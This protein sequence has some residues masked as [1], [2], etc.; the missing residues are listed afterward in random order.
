MIIKQGFFQLV[1]TVFLFGFAL[2][3][4]SAA[5]GSVTQRADTPTSETILLT[6]PVLKINRG[7]GDQ[8]IFDCPDAQ[9][10]SLSGE[11]QI[12]W[13]VMTV[14]LPPDADMSRLSCSITKVKYEP[15]K[16]Q[17]QVSPKPPM[18]TLQNDKPVKIW[19][20]NKTIVNGKDAD[21]YSQNDF[22]PKQQPRILHT[23]K[24]HKYQLAQIAVPLVRYHPINNKLKK[25][26]RAEVTLTFNKKTAHNSKK[27]KSNG[28]SKAAYKRRV[29]EL[30]DNSHASIGLY[31]ESIGEGADLTNMQSMSDPNSGYAIITT[32]QIQSSS[33]KLSDFVLHKESLGFD[34]Q[35]ITELDFGGGAGD[36]AAENIRTWLQNSYLIDNIEYVLLIGDPNTTDGNIPMKNLWPRSGAGDGLEESPSDYYY[37]DMTGNW[38][39]DGDGYFGEW[40]D[41]FGTGGVDRFFEIIVGRIPNYGSITDLDAVFEKLIIY[42]SMLGEDEQWR[43]N[44]L[45]PSDPLSASWPGFRIGEQ[46]KHSILEKNGWSSHRIYDDDYYLNPPP[47]TTPCTMDN[48]IDVWNGNADNSDG[49]FGLVVWSGH[50]NE[51]GVSDIINRS[52]LPLLDDNYPGFTFQASCSNSKPD[53]SDNLSYE[54]LKHGGICTIGATTE[55]YYLIGLAGYNIQKEGNMAYEYT[56]GLIG[57]GF[58]CGRALNDLREVYYPI[59]SEGWL[60]HLT[61]NIYG[62]PSLHIIRMDLADE[63]TP[64]TYHVDALSECADPNGLS[65]TTAF[66]DLQDALSVALEGDEIWVAEGVYTPADPGSGRNISFRPPYGISIYGGF[67]A[68]GG[69][70]DDRNPE[71]YQTVLSG[72]LNGN[73]VGDLNNPSRNENSY[74]VVI[75][76]SDFTL[77]GFTITGGNA[78]IS[79]ATKSS[80]GGMILSHSDATVRNCVFTKNYA[81]SGGALENCYYGRPTFINCAFTGNSGNSG[82]AIY[83][84]EA[85]IALKDCNFVSNNAQDDDGAA[86]KAQYGSYEISNCTFTNNLSA[87]WGG[88]MY[89]SCCDLSLNG[90]TISDNSAKQGAGIHIR[91]ASLTID[92]CILSDNSAFKAGGNYDGIG[93]GI[94]SE[95]SGIEIYNSIFKGNHAEAYAGGLYTWNRDPVIIKNSTFVQNT[96]DAIYSS[97][98]YGDAVLILS[99]DSTVDIRNSIFWQNEH[100]QIIIYR[101]N[102]V[103]TVNNSCIQGGYSGANNISSDPCFVDAANDDFHLKSQAGRWKAADLQWV[104]DTVTSPCIDTGDAASGWTNELW[105]HGKRINMGAYGGTAEASMSSDTS[106]NPADFDKDNDVDFTDFLSMADKW[107]S[108][109]SLL[110]QDIS[111]DNFVNLS[112]FAMFA[113]QWLWQEP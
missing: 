24:L 101:I 105:P 29:Q 40:E 66:D 1:L 3:S 32:S 31:D 42:E 68:G 15:V 12:P 52:S 30:A 2:I 55:S 47:E 80:G 21:I 108:N 72:D 100:D 111:R 71:T 73:D 28:I 103:A 10:L 65:W 95:T 83:I 27:S 78:N 59:S 91:E 63:H 107:F 62:D 81:R 51:A 50:G 98:G 69:D 16:G 45:I 48:V 8:A 19:P 46:I 56:E 85:N 37:A 82:G 54:L 7:Q 96:A 41:D 14:L 49:K 43:K 113:G 61:F 34:V 84:H 97:I 39:L 106:G 67:P 87:R 89:L 38:D 92:N 76:S 110:A 86:I 53:V 6:E 18:S 20:K 60:N 99:R 64:V 104:A 112:D 33:T 77:D 36:V 70:W 13:K 11:P 44:V 17:W 75:G 23:G 79:E 5:N 102:S 22:W 9:Y 109:E 90:C 25:L 35:V 88:A 58:D 94:Y 4:I 57:K 74:H 26:V 93:G